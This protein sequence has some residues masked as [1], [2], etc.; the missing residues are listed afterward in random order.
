MIDKV[1]LFMFKNFKSIAFEFRTSHIL[2]VII[3]K[4][5]TSKSV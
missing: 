2:D 3:L 4:H 5:S 1:V